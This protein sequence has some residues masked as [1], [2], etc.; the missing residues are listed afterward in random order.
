MR[1]VSLGTGSFYKWTGDV[2]KAIAICKNF[3]IDGVE[4]MLSNLNRLN[5]FQPT[6]ENIK[7]LKGLDFNTI[8]LLT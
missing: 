6:Q 1:V 8:I 4:I 5:Q 3:D 7:Y 2:N